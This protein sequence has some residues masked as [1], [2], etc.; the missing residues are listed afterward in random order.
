MSMRGRSLPGANWGAVSSA[1][2]YQLASCT[3]RIACCSVVELNGWEGSSGHAATSASRITD[4]PCRKLHT[5]AGVDDRGA[6]SAP[7]QSHTTSSSDTVVYLSV[8]PMAKEH[9]HALKGLACRKRVAVACSL[10][11]TC[12]Q[13]TALTSPARHAC[14]CTRPSRARLC[15]RS[16]KFLSD[17][18]K[19]YCR[20][21]AVL[22]TQC[23]ATPRRRTHC[24][25]DWTELG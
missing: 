19:T 12:K 21:T 16:S 4:S 22:D 2:K 6:A 23:K 14:G 5:P 13:G 10:A 9:V 20:H 8:H 24:L 25:T 17:G 7:T 11:A 18:S 15:H 3:A 1:R